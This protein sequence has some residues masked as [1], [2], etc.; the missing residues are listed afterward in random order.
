MKEFQAYGTLIFRSFIYS[1]RQITKE[2]KYSQTIEAKYTLSIPDSSFYIK[3]HALA[4][5]L[6]K[7]VKILTIVSYT[8]NF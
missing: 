2:K 6:F 8:T 4:K 7:V 3:Q 1:P 5:G